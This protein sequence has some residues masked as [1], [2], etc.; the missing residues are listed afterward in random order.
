MTIPNNTRDNSAERM[1]RFTE[2]IVRTLE[3]K[4]SATIYDANCG[5]GECIGINETEARQL[6]KLFCDKGYH[7]KAYYI[8][9][10]GFRWI[11]IATYVMSPGSALKSY[12]EVWG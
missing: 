8:R 2:Y 11:E 10:Y 6:A 9:G 5:Y 4:N 3:K 1:E 12:S 7:A